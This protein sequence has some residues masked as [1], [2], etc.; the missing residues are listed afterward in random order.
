MHGWKEVD[1]MV[2]RKRS[3]KTPEVVAATSVKSV[4]VKVNKFSDDE[5]TTERNIEFF[6]TEPAFVRVAAG[7]T[8]N[9]G[10]Y[11]SLRVDVAVTMPCYREEINEVQ[12]QAAD[13]VALRLG[14]EIDTYLGD[15][16]G[17]KD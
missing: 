15:E 13:W 12:K 2:Q 6:E 1:I 7:Q 5:E 10:D 14:E 9:L 4:W 8:V 16:D 17:K 3:R 11:E